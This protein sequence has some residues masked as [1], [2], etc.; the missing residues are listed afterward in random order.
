MQTV[1]RLPDTHAEQI[2]ALA[3][4]QKLSEGAVIESIVKSW[5]E[6]NIHQTSD[7]ASA[8]GLWQDNAAVTDGLS[9]QNQLRDE[10]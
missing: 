6:T 1:I 7:K 5:L 3:R 9:Y 4:K 10:W 8:F 2:I